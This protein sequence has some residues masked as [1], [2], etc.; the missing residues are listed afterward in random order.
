[1]FG[2]SLHLHAQPTLLVLLEW[3]SVAQKK[4]G[5]RHASHRLESS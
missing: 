4:A 3:V 2:L 5:K 1:M